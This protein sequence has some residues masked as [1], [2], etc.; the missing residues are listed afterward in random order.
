M[1]GAPRGP[2]PAGG[3]EPVVGPEPL[4]PERTSG[5]D[6]LGRCAGGWAGSHSQTTNKRLLDAVS[7]GR[8]GALTRTLGHVGNCTHP[9]L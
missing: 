6:P 1:P 4:D 9:S 7:P 5:A 8:D 3:D 2:G